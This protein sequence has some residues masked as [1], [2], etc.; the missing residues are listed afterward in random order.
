LLRLVVA[1][2]RHFLVARCR[3]WGLISS[4]ASVPPP[5]LCSEVVAVLLGGVDAVSLPSSHVL[6]VLDLDLPRR[7][8]GGVFVC[9]GFGLDFCARC[10]AAFAACSFVFSIFPADFSRSTRLH[11]AHM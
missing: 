7:S 2:A 1:S 5:L 4:G 10:L 8:G 3:W 6:S 11:D 9:A